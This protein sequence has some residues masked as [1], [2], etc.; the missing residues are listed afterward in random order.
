MGTIEFGHSTSL[1]N[2]DAS[3]DAIPLPLSAHLSEAP[4]AVEAFV[5][6]RAAVLFAR[7]ATTPKAVV[8]GWR[9]VFRML[10]IVIFT[11][12]AEWNGHRRTPSLECAAR[13]AVPHA[14]AVVYGRSFTRRSPKRQ[15]R[16]LPRSA[17]RAEGGAT[18]RVAAVSGVVHAW[19]ARCGAHLIR[20]VSSLRGRVD[21]DVCFQYPTLFKIHERVDRVPHVFDLR[22]I[23]TPRPIRQV[24]DCGIPN[25]SEELDVAFP[26]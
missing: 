24:V 19:N 8:V 11:D 2:R 14:W 18:E 15:H 9:P 23:G 6:L 17:E 7:R 13:P 20:G 12:V 4:D 21:V 3:N 10:W 16:A 22:R 5:V 1:A 25:G 26:A